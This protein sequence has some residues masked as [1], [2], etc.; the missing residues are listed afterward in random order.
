V[1]D[2]QAHS[3]SQQTGKVQ[4]AAKPD[5]RVKDPMD[6][7]KIGSILFRALEE[8][9]RL[10]W[11]GA[12]VAKALL[13]A[14]TAAAKI[15]QLS[16]E[17]AKGRGMLETEED[18]MEEAARLAEAVHRC[19]I[20]VTDQIEAMRKVI[21]EKD[22]EV[23]E[24]ER[25]LKSIEEWIGPL[26]QSLEAGAGIVFPDQP[27]YKERRMEMLETRHYTRVAVHRLEDIKMT[28]LKKIKDKKRRDL[29]EETPVVPKPCRM[30]G[31][32][33][34]GSHRLRDCEDFQRKP[35]AWKLARLR[36]WRLCLFCYGHDVKQECFA[37]NNRG[38]RGC[39]AY[40]CKEH[41]NRD[42]HFTLTAARLFSVHAQ[43]A[44]AESEAQTF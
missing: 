5:P 35:A 7:N 33:C 13:P 6:G 10:G 20:M 32:G 37:K 2:H 11:Q 21:W 16:G 28:L 42:L 9:A 31:Q 29:A 23:K 34:T 25:M 8:V 40:G 12:A 43:P 26:E 17:A 18:Q 14:M 39:S 30:A 19:F 38:Y 15:G 24:L 3:M 1:R 4:K 22:H 27:E 44:E 36:E 41:H